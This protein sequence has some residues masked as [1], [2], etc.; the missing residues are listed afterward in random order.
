M[1]VSSFMPKPGD[2][3]EQH[4]VVSRTLPTAVITA[5]NTVRHIMPI[6]GSEIAVD[7]MHDLYFYKGGSLTV[8]G[9][10][11]S[12]AGTVTARIVKRNS[13]GTFTNLSGTVTIP[14]GT[15]A[16]SVLVFPILATATGDQRTI[17]PNSGDTLWVEVVATAG[18]T[19]QPGDVQAA[20]KLAV[21]R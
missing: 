13:A 15:G 2:F 20:V 12:T 18:V 5:T 4:V 6:V 8:G 19:T 21:L 1:R 7:R 9:P 17:R 16:G 11:S 3:G 14:T 10:A